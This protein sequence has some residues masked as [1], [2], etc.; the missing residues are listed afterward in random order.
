VKLRPL[1]TKLHQILG[2][3]S[4]LFLVALG[5]S[6]ALMVW[7]HDVDQKLNPVLFQV[8]PG[9]G[10]W[11]ADE[12]MGL[13]SREFP[14]DRILGL[15]FPHHHESPFTVAMQS[16]LATYVDPTG[17]RVLGQ[18]SLREGF[19]GRIHALH[20]TLL[21]G[22]I[23]AVVVGV[24]TLILV[25]SLVSGL[26]LWWPRRVV[27][28]ALGRTWKRTNFDLHNTVGFFSFAVLLVIAITGVGMSFRSIMDPIIRS[29]TG[30]PAPLPPPHAA[31]TPEAQPLSFDT[32]VEIAEGALPGAIPIS[33]GV[34][35]PASGVFRL[36]KRF[37]E[38]RT[39][40]GRSV[41]Y[42][43]RFTGEVLRVD[44]TRAAPLGTRLINLQRSLHTGELF[45]LPG[46]VVAFIACLMLLAQVVSGFLMWSAR[47]KGRP[48]LTRR[49]SASAALVNQQ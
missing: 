5:A 36:Q 34:P 31:A 35:A 10:H 42:L 27:T 15:S 44:S 49:A 32:L 28:V 19:L 43:N 1:I 22:R 17:P 6:G 18:R 25:V 45:G 23:G 30:S 3:A 39:P 16:G 14:A 24:V 47:W 21:G 2:L 8:A 40:G 41:V 9:H 11:S 33:F 38:D 29:G 20:L 48:A 46:Q 13:V 12:V 4:G 7:A 37:P 26:Y